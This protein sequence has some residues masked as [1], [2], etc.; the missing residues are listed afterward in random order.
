MTARS[1]DVSDLPWLIVVIYLFSSPS[2]SLPTH[3]VRH[4]RLEVVKYLIEVQDC[5]TGCT[6]YWK[7]IPL[8]YACR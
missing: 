5:S 1:T 3:I 6:D 8:H 2:S 4:G 7:R